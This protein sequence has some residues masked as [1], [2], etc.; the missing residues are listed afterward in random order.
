M[1]KLLVVGIIILFIG[2]G[3]QSAFATEP[4]KSTD[5]TKEEIE[6]KDYLFETI[7]AIANNTDIQ[8][9]LEENNPNIINFDY[10]SKYIFRK[11]LFRNPEL[12]F[13]IIFSKPEMTTQYLDKTYNQGIELIDIIGEE[14]AY[15]MLDS[16]ENINPNLLD[17]LN[18]II[19]KDEELANRIS[20]L[21][22]LNEENDEICDILYLLLIITI[23]QG[24]ALIYLISI[25]E[26]FPLLLLCIASRGLIL[27]GRYSIIG[28]LLEL[29]DC[30]WF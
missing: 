29:Y 2:V 6:P 21:E 24:S 20:I 26:D 18:N 16:V 28:I 5:I 1:K 25:F 15:E 22:E 12:L 13:S 14:K 23:I 9:L 27:T 4:I 8:D 3:V 19:M 7:V 30:W 17:N 11:L 10:N